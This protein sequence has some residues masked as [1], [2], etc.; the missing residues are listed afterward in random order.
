MLKQFQAVLV[1]QR[2]ELETSVFCDEVD[3]II[4]SLYHTSIVNM[5]KLNDAVN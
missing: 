2:P 5:K 3:D 1:N 4:C